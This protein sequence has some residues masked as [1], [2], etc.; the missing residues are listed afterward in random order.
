MVLQSKAGRHSESPPS[1]ASCSCDFPSRPLFS[2]SPA[3][4]R[5]LLS[6]HSINCAVPSIS[7]RSFAFPSLFALCAMN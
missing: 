2:R 6:F 4:S 3:I 5:R 7:A 1:C